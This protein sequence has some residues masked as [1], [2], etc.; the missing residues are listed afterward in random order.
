MKSDSK[1]SPKWEKGRKGRL[2]GI[3]IQEVSGDL[4]D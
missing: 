2:M 4:G 3:D 1:P